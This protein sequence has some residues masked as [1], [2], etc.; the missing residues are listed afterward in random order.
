MLCPSWNGGGKS[1]VLSVNEYLENHNYLG[2]LF[3]KESLIG[4]YS[5]FNWVLIPQERV[6]FSEEYT[7][8]Y[9]MV[10]NSPSV[11]TLEYSDRMI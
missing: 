8:V 6:R 4:F 9:T 7:G 10:Y 11:D 5:K 1:L 2:I 3:C